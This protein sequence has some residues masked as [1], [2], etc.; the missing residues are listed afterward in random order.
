M[1]P[2]SIIGP[3][4]TTNRMIHTISTLT[5]E[6]EYITL[7]DHNKTSESVMSGDIVDGKRRK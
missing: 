4:G 2:P 7:P 6:E 1:R 5:T 3:R